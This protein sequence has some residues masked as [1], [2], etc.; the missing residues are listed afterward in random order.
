MTRC[1]QNTSKESSS[2]FLSRSWASAQKPGLGRAVERPVSRSAKGD[3]RKGPLS[4]TFPLFRMS[5]A[6][7]ECSCT[8]WPGYF[9]R[10][11][12]FQTDTFALLIPIKAGILWF[13][14][15]NLVFYAY[16]LNAFASSNPGRSCQAV[17]RELTYL[18]W[19][20]LFVHR[21]VWH[22]VVLETAVFARLFAR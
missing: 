17:A 3:F 4:K 8:F 11:L 20:D 2:V 7:L 13:Q 12:L 15:K 21:L 14:K 9:C 19:V 10:S 6:Q 16:I 22:R 18:T 1:D 5:I